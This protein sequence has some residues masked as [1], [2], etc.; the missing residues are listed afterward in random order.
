MTP[1]FLL[2]SLP[3]AVPSITPAPSGP[4]HVKGNLILDAKGRQYLIRGTALPPI[5]LDRASGFGPFS[6]TT[7]ITIRQRMNMNAVRIRIDAAQY[8]SNPN[9]RAFVKDVVKNANHLELLAILE[10]PSPKL[11][12]DFKSNPNVFFAVSDNAVVAQFRSAGATQP[13]ILNDIAHASTP[14]AD[15]NV[16]YQ[17]TPTFQNLQSGPDQSSPQLANG[18]DPNLIS[19]GPECET[20]PSDPAAASKLIENVLTRFDQHYINW[21]ISA[22]EPGKL[23]D[24]YTAYDWSKLDDGWTCGRPYSGAGIGMAVLSHLWAADAHGVFT[25]NQPAGGLVIA[26]GANASAYGR[27]LAEREAQGKSL[28]LS[29]ISIKVTD[30]R[31]VSRP[32]RLLWTGGGW[33]STNL[34]IPENSA[35]GPAE[36]TIVRTDGSKSSSQIIIAD[37]A[38]GLWT[39]SADGRGPIVAQMLEHSVRLEGTG[40]RYAHSLVAIVDGIS[41]PVESFGAI[42]G[43]SRDLV[44][45]KRIGQGEKDIFL[46]ADGKLSNVARI[47]LAPTLSH[48]VAHALVR[49]ASPRVAPS[50]SL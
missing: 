27:I 3:F 8:E 21:T 40:F 17:F 22:M 50:R 34:I 24:N 28:K 29:N 30:S 6:R 12:A 7:L 25:V 23:I 32:A 5:T 45:I 14:G 9:Y 26:R 36:V 41:V 37:A 33:S 38:P 43:T 16:I 13:I 2:L 19:A 48:P 46:I 31:G 39:P 1:W 47:N 4:Y 44:T 49:A 11:A 35:P 18:L 10:S 42:P 20:F 15:A